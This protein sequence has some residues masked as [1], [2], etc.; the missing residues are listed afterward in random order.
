MPDPGRQAVAVISVHASP[1]SELGRGENGGMNL[2]IR[3]VCEGLAE[4][5]VPT[6]V[7]VRRDDR[8]AP[9]E[10]LIAPGSR[11]VRLPVGPPA[12][13]PKAEVR[14]LCDDFAAAVVRHARSEGRRYRIVH[15]HYWHAGL[16]AE[17]L[18]S[19]WDVPWVQS[20]H[21]LA[22]TKAR[23]GLPLEEDRAEA[24]AALVENADRL[25]AASVSEAKDLIRL[26]RAPRDRICVAQPGVDLRLFEPR[27]TSAVRRSLGLDGNRV[28]F[29][30]GRL[31]PLKGAD[32]LLEAAQRLV[33]RPEFADLT[34]LV[35]GD[36]SQDGSHGDGERARLQ[37]SAEEGSLAGR[38][39]F[40][41][42][43]PHEQLPDLYALAEVCVVP[44]RTESFGF[45]ALEA[46]ALGTPVVAAAVGG[47]TEV[48]EDGVTGVLVPGRDA[49]R[50]AD[51]IASVLSDPERRGAM[52]EAA[53][54]RATTFTWARAVE[55]VGAIYARLSGEATPS[56]EPCG[57]DDEAVEL[58]RAG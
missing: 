39:R 55:R 1:L 34:L 20:F 23:A 16:V 32:T 4:R 47:L 7:F 8:S 13:I 35:A 14:R 12:P 33:E 27:D 36:D 38:V 3:R 50:W 37:R 42:A 22:R 19:S 11:L 21:T 25:V 48:V 29:F 53:R 51:A 44:S 49:S 5:G 56:A 31:E 24:E 9:D 41:G 52:G 28:V 45:V 57:Y 43:V 54:Q 10:Q 26:Y 15:A 18:R 2:A 17:Q 58:L 6:D 40:L 30:A 46:Q